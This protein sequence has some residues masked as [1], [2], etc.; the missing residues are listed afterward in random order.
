M[1]KRSRNEPTSVQKPEGKIQAWSRRASKG[2]E[3]TPEEALAQSRDVLAWSLKKNGPDSSFTIK[4]M[5]EVANQLEAQDLRADE[6]ALR[7]Q[8]M[9][10]LAR[11]LGPEDEATLKAELQLALALIAIGRSEDAVAPLHHVV[12]TRASTF[13]PDAP[14]TLL[15]MAW[16]ANV[17]KEQGRLADACDLQRRI[18]SGYALAGT[19]ES[20]QAMT[21][22]LNLASTLADLDQSDEAA[23]LLGRVLEVRR[24]TLG[25]DDPKS[26]EVLEHL[27]PALVAAGRVASARDMA[28]ALVAWR[29][30]ASGPEAAETVRA[31]ALLAQVDL[32]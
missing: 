3:P 30:A 19:E 32:A 27:V 16:S 2:M 20:A 10:A 26:L 7:Q 24:R 8:V 21:A 14:E 1:G 29:T 31:R 23:D 17:A 15:A 11:T 22:T 12:E 13:G 9:A 28:V 18:V 25:P 6:V 5:V 4:A